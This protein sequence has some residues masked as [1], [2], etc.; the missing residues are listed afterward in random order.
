MI[1]TQKDE[2]CEVAARKLSSSCDLDPKLAWLVMA[3]YDMFPV[4]ES[5][6]LSAV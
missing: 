2:A 5:V 6:C 1:H 3:T 4:G